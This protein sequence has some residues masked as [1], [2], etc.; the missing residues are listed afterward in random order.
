MDRRTAIDW[1]DR[2]VVALTAAPPRKVVGPAAE[3]AVPPRKVAVGSDRA[4]VAADKTE[5]EPEVASVDRVVAA[6]RAELG[7]EPEIADKV[8]S[9]IADKVGAGPELGIGP[10][11][12]PEVGAGPESEAVAG[13]GFVAG[14]ER[15][16]SILANRHRKN[17]AE[18]N[19][20]PAD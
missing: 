11:L 3:T 9:G 18:Q 8:V 17:S 12:E 15:D 10:E 20:D 7:A 14:P 4:I 16:R 5:L 6:D 19:Q 2:R 1:P 13:P